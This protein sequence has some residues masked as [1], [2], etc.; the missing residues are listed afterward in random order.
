MILLNLFLTDSRCLMSKMSILILLDQLPP[1]P[2]L[3]LPQNLELAG[4]KFALNVA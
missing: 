4:E 2:I 3:L 1:P